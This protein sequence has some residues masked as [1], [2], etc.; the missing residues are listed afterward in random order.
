MGGRVRYWSS[1]DVKEGG[2]RT[3]SHRTGLETALRQSWVRHL[4]LVTLPLP[5]CR[6]VR[7]KWGCFEDGKAREQIPL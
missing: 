4:R 1:Y 2:L 5:Q 6:L 7:L 3:P